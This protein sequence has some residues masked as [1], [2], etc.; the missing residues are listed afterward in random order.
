MKAHTAA[1]VLRALRSRLETSHGLLTVG[2]HEV[3][4][5]WAGYE[6]SNKDQQVLRVLGLSVT[7][8]SLSASGMPTLGGVGN[9][10]YEAIRTAYKALD[11]KGDTSYPMPPPNELGAILQAGLA[12]KDEK[13]HVPIPT[14]DS[15][16]FTKYMEQLMKTEPPID[17]KQTN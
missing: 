8:I 4:A 13:T 14:S 3:Y 16:E 10:E 15:D 6:A 12:K 2:M 1:I 5:L 11:T 9:D 7:T 17:P